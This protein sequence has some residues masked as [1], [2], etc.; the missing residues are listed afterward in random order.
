MI[1][2]RTLLSGSA[3]VLGSA[4][5]PG[6]ASL[7]HGNAA[8][9]RTL[10]PLF[11]EIEKRTFLY[12]WET[13]NR[14][15]GL[16]P[17]RW[18]SPSFCSIAAVGFAL[19]CY[20]I[21]V[22]RGWCSRQEARDLT[23]TTLR[24]FRSA[25]QGPAPSGTAGHKGFFYHFLDM[26]TGHR[27][28][29]VELSTV[30]STIL[31]MGILFAGAWYDRD[32]PAEAE[33][34]ALAHEIYARADWG[35][36]QDGREAITMGWHPET[37]FIARNWDGYNE[38]MFVY[39]LGLGAPE[40]PM[41][42]GSWN[43]WTAPYPRFWRG[44]GDTRHL[45]FAPLFGHQYSHV[46]IDFRGIRDA[47][48]RQAGFDYFENSR[49]ATYANRAYCAANPMGWEG[50]SPD[51]WGLTACD[52]PGN[53]E[54]GYKGRP[55]AFYGYAARGPLGQP[56]PRDDGTIAPTAALASL[57]FAPEI[58]IPCA[59]AMHRLHGDRLF[60]RY[61][62]LDSFNPSFT[63]Q[64]LKLERGAAD[65]ERGWVNSD[66]LGIDQGPIL[67]MAANHRDDFVWRTMRKVPAIRCGLEQAGFTG[68]WLST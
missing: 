29:R 51:I 2:R 36:F 60:G 1:D 52:G 14:A 38:G 13:V 15:N 25:P 67:A 65:P 42:A 33:I 27:F 50:Y 11:D 23:L 64:G 48:M 16:V 18:P 49:R 24:F 10:P 9:P 47:A 46:W 68:G 5:L 53:F 57:P 56:D 63:Y 34:R 8:A 35:W 58:V 44:E 39:I 66:W 4:V 62:F 6:C 20:P 22:E 28:E 59:E 43:A 40:R 17:D 7:P 12:F 3:L 21:G 41:A 54:L 45:A 61:G 19:T 31:F 30:D 32:D 26:E 55:A 37:G